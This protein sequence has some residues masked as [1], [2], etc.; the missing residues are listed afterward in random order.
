M[1]NWTENRALRASNLRFRKINKL[2]HEVAYLWG[3]VD[4]YV[5]GLCDQLIRHAD[6]AHLELVASV[7]ARA[8][9]R[10]AAE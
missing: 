5:V 2:L 8:E 7:Q 6:N 10:E 9:E 3:D 1:K 4:E